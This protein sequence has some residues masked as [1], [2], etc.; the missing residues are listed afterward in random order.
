MTLIGIVIRRKQKWLA[1]FVLFLLSHSLYHSLYLSINSHGVICMTLVSGKISRVFLVITC[2]CGSFPHIPKQVVFSS[3]CA[4]NSGYTTPVHSMCCF[5]SLSFHHFLRYVSSLQLLLKSV[6]KFLLHS[7]LRGEGTISISIV[8]KCPRMAYLYHAPLRLL[9]WMGMTTE[10]ML[11]DSGHQSDTKSQRHY[12]IYC[13]ILVI[14]L[15]HNIFT[16]C[17]SSVPE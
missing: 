3:P 11:F 15:I 16:S 9:F 4:S 6:I 2:S 1:E 17:P 10:L 14:V 13:L 12:H 5:R 8:T 7:R